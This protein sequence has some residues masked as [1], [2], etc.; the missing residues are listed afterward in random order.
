MFRFIRRKYHLWRMARYLERMTKGPCE[1]C[2]DKWFGPEVF[3]K[4][5][6]GASLSWGMEIMPVF[7]WRS[8]CTVCGHRWVKRG[9]IP[10]RYFKDSSECQLY[11][12][13]GTDKWPVDPVTGEKLKIEAGSRL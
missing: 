4:K 9:V 12:P 11:F 8:R 2:K 10:M 5:C 13:N 6:V 1:H 3:T 7:E